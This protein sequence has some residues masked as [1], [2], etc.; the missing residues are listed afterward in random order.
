MP[1]PIDWSVNNQGTKREAGYIQF[2]VAVSNGEVIILIGA[3]VVPIALISFVTV[4]PLLRQLGKGKF[5]MQMERPSGG[6]GGP[7]P[8]PASDEVREAEIRQMLEAKAYRQGERGE[9]PL[10]VDDE[11][12]R[13]TEERPATLAS[14]P[15]L[16]DEI[17]QLAIARNER[18]ERQGKE[19]LDID[20]EVERQLR[21][22]EDL[23]Q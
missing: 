23:G 15:Q 7:A 6:G 11:Y 17:R 22:L 12:K 13:L 16:V 21:D 20:A 2:V 18:R 14:D 8:A 10:D 3:L 1:A 5:A 19:P 4:G 9:S